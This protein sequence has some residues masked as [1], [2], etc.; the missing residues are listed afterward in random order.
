MLEIKGY[1]YAAG[2]VA[3]LALLVGAFFY[4]EHRVE[5][6]DAAKFSAVAQ[7]AK[8]AQAETDRTDKA[9]NYVTKDAYNELQTKLAGYSAS[10]D[11]LTQRVHDSA[12]AGRPVIVSGTVA[13][14]CQ[15]ADQGTAREAEAGN[16]RPVES[17]STLPTE[18][19]R[20]D[21]TLALQN[22]EALQVVIEASDKVQR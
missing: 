2:A 12:S 5:V 8:D 21:L 16:P 14:T 22:I 7:Q 19:L 20:D 4:G 13:A 3:I 9:N 18:I 15:P 17:A 1:L 6:Q 11:D 10:V